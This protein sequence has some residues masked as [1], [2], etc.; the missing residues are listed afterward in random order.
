MEQNLPS[1]QK[2]ARITNIDQYDGT[3]DPEDH[4]DAFEASMF[5]HGASD[6]IICRAFSLTLKHIAL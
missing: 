3:T 2:F 4:L 6:P 1:T 5:F